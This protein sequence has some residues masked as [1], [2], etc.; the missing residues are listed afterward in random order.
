MSVREELAEVKKLVQDEK[1]MV[2]DKE[3]EVKK[4]KIEI[5]RFDQESSKKKLLMA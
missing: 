3:N 5:G 4:I 1:I 2:E